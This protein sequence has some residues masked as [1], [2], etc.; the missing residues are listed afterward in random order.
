MQIL[1]ENNSFPKN[2]LLNWS[3]LGAF[4]MHFVKKRK[5]MKNGLPAGLKQLAAVK[6]DGCACC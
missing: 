5:E 6:P 2:N 3:D 1:G 4:N